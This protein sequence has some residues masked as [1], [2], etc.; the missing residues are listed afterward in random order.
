MIAQVAQQRNAS[1][2]VVDGTKAK[3]LR[4]MIEGDIGLELK[5]RLRKTQIEVVIVPQ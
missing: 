5:R 2:V 4:R 1:Y 3:G